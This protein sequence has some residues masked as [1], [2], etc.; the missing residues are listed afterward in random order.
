MKRPFDDQV[1]VV[2]IRILFIAGLVTAIAWSPSTASC[3]VLWGVS[4]FAG[5]DS[6]SIIRIDDYDTNPTMFDLGET[7]EMLYDIAYDPI[8]G[9]LYALGRFTLF[10]IEKDTFNL[11]DLGT[12]NLLFNSFDIRDD[13]VAFIAGANDVDDPGR[14]AIIDL[15]DASRT[16]LGPIGFAPAGDLM[17]DLDG[18]LYATTFD[19]MLGEINPLTGVGS[20]IGPTNIGS[21]SFGAEIDSQGVI[22]ASGFPANFETTYRLYTLDKTTGNST[23]VGEI[24]NSDGLGINGLTFV[25]DAIPEPSTG[26]IAILACA[27]MG[28][29]R[30]RRS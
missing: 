16:N 6:S 12:T 15:S 18:K 19:G 5:D 22:Y 24:V 14:F 2:L 29:I 4:S 11:V 23:L 21:P 3:D 26:L 8:S 10:L 27:G 1:V 9:N 17:F 28:L 30:R 13:G 25:P 20:I 7:G